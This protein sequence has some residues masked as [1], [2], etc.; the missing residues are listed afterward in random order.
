MI[1]ISHASS[2]F[3][4]LIDLLT[5]RLPEISMAPTPCLETMIPKN[6]L[7]TFVWDFGRLIIFVLHN[8]IVNDGSV[9]NVGCTWGRGVLR[10]VE[11]ELSNVCNRGER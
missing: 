4:V 11:H 5:Y 10:D 6:P 9:N 2:H 8:F 3:N 1:I 7:Q